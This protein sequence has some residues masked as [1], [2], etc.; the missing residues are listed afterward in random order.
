MQQFCSHICMFLIGIRTI[1]GTIW[2][3]NNIQRF[4]LV[5]V[6][7][8]PIPFFHISITLYLFILQE[9]T[10]TSCVFFVFFVYWKELSTCCIS[11]GLCHFKAQHKSLLSEKRSRRHGRIRITCKVN[12]LGSRAPSIFGMSLLQTLL[13]HNVSNS[14]N[15]IHNRDWTYSR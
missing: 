8:A 1:F 3:L 12:L 11:V 7:L 4:R 15:N 14:I 5:S 13:T 6:L 2:K 9:Q 10:Y